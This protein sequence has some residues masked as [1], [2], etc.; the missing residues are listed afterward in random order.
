MVRT[1][2]FVAAAV[3]T[4]IATKHSLQPPPACKLLTAA[5][6]SKVVG[7]PVVVDS[8]GARVDRE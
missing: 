6:A 7:F 1:A 3:M 8:V 4:L 5:E 2:G